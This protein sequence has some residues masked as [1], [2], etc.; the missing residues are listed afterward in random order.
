M[1]EGNVPEN[2]RW[3][4]YRTLK[5]EIEYLHFLSEKTDEHSWTR[6]IWQ[7]TRWR[8]RSTADEVAKERGKDLK[9]EGV[10]IGSF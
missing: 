3:V 10:Y 4:V 7:A 2:P 1:F 8:C 5:D 6:D 9:V